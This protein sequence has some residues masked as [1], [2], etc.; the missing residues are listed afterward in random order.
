M[1]VKSRKTAPPSLPTA[2]VEAFDG[3]LTGVVSLEFARRT[4][5]AALENDLTCDS[6]IQALLDEAYEDTR[7]S[8]EDYAVL[9]GELRHVVSED[10]PTDWSEA[11][12]NRGP[13]PGPAPHASGGFAADA[14]RE[15]SRRTPQVSPPLYPGAVLRQRFILQSRMAAG[16][17]G[18][19]YK[20]LDRRKQEAGAPDPFVAIKVISPGFSSFPNA[21][22]CLRQE[23]LV[24][25]QLLHPNI[26]RILDFDR[27]DDHAFITMEWLEGESLAALLTRLRYRPLA[28]ARARRILK[29]IGAALTHAHSK[30]VVHGDVKPGNIFVTTNGAAKLLDF[31]VARSDDGGGSQSADGLAARTPAYSSCETLEGGA[32]TRQDDLFSLACVAYRMLAG[33]RAFA[34]LTALEAERAGRHPPRITHVPDGPWRALERALSFRRH[35]RQVGIAEFLR[36][37]AAEA[38]VRAGSSL[39]TVA[40]AAARTVGGRSRP[41]I[42]TLG[43]GLAAGA[44]AV[45]ILL[46]PHGGTPIPTVAPV[47]ESAAAPAMPETPSPG[48]G[49][50]AAPNGGSGAVT[51]IPVPTAGTDGAATAPKPVA[52]ARDAPSSTR[53]PAAE[54]PAVARRTTPPASPGTA[55]ALRDSKRT[56]VSTGTANTAGAMPATASGPE[57]GS[58]VAGRGADTAPTVAPPPG[59]KETEVSLTSLKFTR[60]VEPVDQSGGIRHIDRAGWVVISF[61]VDAAGKTQDVKAVDADP[62]GR[63]QA[64]ISAVRRWRF[65]PILDDGVPVERTSRVR[66]RFELK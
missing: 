25:Q 4:L 52:V 18:E 43:A 34:R 46:R 27:D 50:P 30:G 57:P 31:G 8:D 53:Q 6:A 59:P 38:T 36:E 33:K 39:E 29:D 3:L 64:A 9:N 11:A 21:V 51:R 1:H 66:V 41:R 7:L 47:P 56:A 37:F 44:M 17:M 65:Q 13:A 5:I 63:Y 23:A 15:A 12:A 55:T 26:V 40:P 10:V 54:K 61:R 2:F 42:F 45:A 49:V 62:P 20:A 16:S 48:N 14:G 35:H 22:K 58:P 32:P 19:I 60:Y 28:S 24:G